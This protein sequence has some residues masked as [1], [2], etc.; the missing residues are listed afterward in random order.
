[1]SSN[2]D[3]PA[4]ASHSDGWRAHELSQLRRFRALSLRRKLEAVEGM[5]DVVRRLDQMRRE[6]KF[7]SGS[8]SPTP[9]ETTKKQAV[10]E[11]PAIYQRA[12]VSDDLE[13]AGCA[14][15]PLMA[16]LKALGILRIVS[17][18][19]DKG[20][21]GWWKNDVFWLRSTLDKNALVRFFSEEYKPTPMFSPWNGDGGF[22]SDTGTSVSIVKA[23][24]DSSHPRLK[25]IR[26]AIAAVDQIPLMADFREKRDRSKDLEKKKKSRKLSDG[27]EE[28]RRQVAARLKRIKQSVVNAVRGGFSDSS[29]QWL[30]ACMTLNMNGFT[31]SPLLGSGGV[32]GR[33]DFGTNFLLNVQLLISDE[34][35]T[36]WFM[37]SLFSE[38]THLAESSIGQ[39]SPGQIGGPNGT[40]GFEGISLINPWDF[41]LMM[42][43]SLL[44]A[45]AAVRRFGAIGDSRPSFPFTARSIASGFDS[46]ATRDEAES[47]G[48]LWLPLWTRST[49]TSELRQLFGEGRAEVSG[50]LAR[51]GTDFARAVAG[52]G[53]DRGI[54]GFSR[55]GFLKRSGKAFL[56][57]PLG[58]FEVVER[59]G[60]DLLREIDRWLDDF[61]WKCARGRDKVEAPKRILS[62]LND[63]DSAIF[64]FCKYGGSQPF[65]DIVIALGRGERQLAVMQG[66]FK[67]KTVKPIPLLSSAW[68][69]KADDGSPEFRVARALV[70]IHHAS[71]GA[72]DQPKL[73]P[74]R[75]NLEAVDW[76]KRCREWAEKDRAVVWNAADLTTNLVNVLERRMMDG[77]RAGCEC[78]P[79]ASRFAVPLDMVAKFLAGEFDDH[80]IV[81]L[82]WG[83]MLIDDRGIQTPDRQGADHT[84]VPRA[85]ALLKLLFLPRPL[86]IERRADGRRFARL[87]R[88][89][90]Q[91][92]IVIRPEPS[93]LSLLRAGRLGEA[94]V[95]A[96]RRLR[97]SG[98]APMPSPI[99]GRRMR[100]HDWRELD[101]M[102]GSGINPQRL[103]AAL[104]I[105]IR[106]DAVNRLI[107]LVMCGDD[108][109]DD[110]I[111]MIA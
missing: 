65:Q 46:A 110:Q 96:M 89:N 67:R 26:D 6:G 107:A 28:E 87:L 61:R 79:L 32:D 71:D 76:K 4:G 103:A 17:E 42:E 106:E 58:R 97:A 16:Y 19:K 44:L 20:A 102:G 18:Q 15:E 63:I 86:V 64:E 40:Q 56:A 14:P 111:E 3:L 99:G 91:G 25:P 37:Q 10:G 23:I 1:M 88:D 34:R 69:S 27:E 2:E 9:R 93:I 66:Q 73:G 84:T 5:A 55:V 21:R 83:L 100:D 80:R 50:R 51:H 52:L 22:L 11:P 12:P 35:Q 30:D 38:A 41:V 78:L 53:V 70:G 98:L 92:G 57:A 75:A 94:C 13:L 109:H 59:S 29:L 82:I 74:L 7:R 31:P 105:P 101:H 49:S 81:D 39:F 8:H 36:E 108:I 47:R 24:R 72:G 43:G 90:E 45:G 85:Y 62:T 95:I 48:E 54:A 104:L 60:V 77:A 33:L 68:M